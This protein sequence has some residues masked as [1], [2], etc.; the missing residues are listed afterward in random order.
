[1]FHLLNN[2]VTP[3]TINHMS[4]GTAEDWAHTNHK[5]FALWLGFRLPREQSTWRT[6][7]G[8]TVGD[9]Q[10]AWAPNQPY[11]NL[12]CAVLTWDSS[13][14]LNDAYNAS[15]PNENV[16][17][18]ASTCVIGRDDFTGWQ[19]PALCKLPAGGVNTPNGKLGLF[20]RSPAYLIPMK[21]S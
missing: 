1:V 2:T 18:E 19:M 11:G 17:W 21:H 20:V 5:V 4:S 10:L 9:A 8:D 3:A 6:M 12:P 14:T 13:N 15:W 16:A 7:A